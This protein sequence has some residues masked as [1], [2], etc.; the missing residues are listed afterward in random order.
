[1]LSIL[2]EIGEPCGTDKY[3]HGYLENYEIIKK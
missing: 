1:M 2:E 3:G